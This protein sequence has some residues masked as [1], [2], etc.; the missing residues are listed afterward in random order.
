MN[1]AH[2][3]VILLFYQDFERDT[4]F[5]HDRYVKRIVRPVYHAISKKQKVSGFFVWYQL[6]VKALRQAGYDVHLNNYTLAR[7][8]P[9][10]PV[11]LVGYPHL[12]HGW[13]LPNPA[14]LGPSLFDHPLQAPNL[15][16]DPRY[17]LYLVTCDWM[18]AMFAPVYGDRCVL[19]YAGIDT[20]QWPDTRSHPKDIDVLVY[21]KIRW[22]REQY[23][24]ALLNPILQILQERGLRYTTIRYRHYD[25]DTYKALL[26]RSRSMIFLCEH[27]TQGL[28]YQE[29]LAS[30]VPI[31]AWENGFWLDPDREKYDPNPVPASSVPYFSPICGERFP[32]FAA[33]PATFARFWANLDTYQP[34]TFVQN[35]LSLDGSAQRY[36]QYYSAIAEGKR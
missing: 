15:L 33:F 8:H 4:F 9:N 14:L 30:N 23:E 3:R 32:D 22:N 36:L 24:P 18:R 31:L 5:K 2:D 6:L 21:D 19:W 16:Q 26:Q 13:N 12:L 20:H 29:A 7:K 35:E 10:Y 25:H 34:R 17:K 28:A 1:L 11:G 27:E